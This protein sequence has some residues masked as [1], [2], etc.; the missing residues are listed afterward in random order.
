MT[1]CGRIAIG[2]PEDAFRG[3][4]QQIPGDIRHVVQRIAF[5]SYV[6]A[7]KKESLLRG[8]TGIKF[9]LKPLLELERHRVPVRLKSIEANSNRG[10]AW[11][12]D[13]SQFLQK[14]IHD[15]AIHGAEEK[16]W[17]CRRSEES[18]ST[19][20]EKSAYLH[21]LW[22]IEINHGYCLVCRGVGIDLQA[23]RHQKE[24]SRRMRALPL[25]P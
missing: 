11:Q 10:G 17:A 5:W 16:C 23:I 6:P 4:R 21:N 14:A 25:R 20:Q 15:A 19:K 3:D 2:D 12:P 7:R 22:M 24:D 9:L 8:L 13:A 1:S 18:H